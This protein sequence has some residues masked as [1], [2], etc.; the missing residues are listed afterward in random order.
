MKYTAISNPGHKVIRVFILLLF[1][2]LVI[3]QSGCGRR[4]RSVVELQKGVWFVS[5]D[6]G[7]A[8]RFDGDG[9]RVSGEYVYTSAALATPVPFEGFV[10]KRGQLVIPL[11]GDPVQVLRGV[12]HLKTSGYLFVAE[13]EQEYRFHA[14]PL[15]AMPV[16]PGRFAVPK[17]T[18]VTRVERVYGYAPGYYASKPVDDMSASAYPAIIMSVLQDVTV[19]MFRDSI[20]LDMDVYRPA[21]DSMVNRP[22]LVLIHGGAFVVGDKRDEFVISL[23]T[24]YA[25]C[26]YVVASINYRMGYP[27]IPGMYSQLERAIFRGVQDVRAALR[28]LSHHRDEFG[29]DPQKVILAGHSA[30]GFYS[31]LTTFKNEGEEWPSSSQ[32]LFGVRRELGCLDC[33]G[34]NLKGHYRILGAVNMWGGI[35]ELDLIQPEEEVPVL[36]IHGT[37]DRIVP[38]GYDFPFA[39]INPRLTA[40]FTRRLYGSAPIYDHMR[41]LGMDVRYIPIP[42]GAHEP[43]NNDSAVYRMIRTETGSFMHEMIGG[44]PLKLSGPVLVSESDEVSKYI[45]SNRGNEEVRWQVTGGIIVRRGHNWADVVWL[46]PASRYVV[47][48]A[49]SNN[50]GVVKRDRLEVRVSR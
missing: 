6:L 40:F 38:A 13:D 8:I 18:G 16:Y 46:E 28:Y 45:V 33:S 42:G 2:G 19:N 4:V 48:A 25:Q 50:I 27:F 37:D 44:K 7:I 23:A 39:R 22:L 11:G 24:H 34:N 36:L 43:Q 20:L 29:I 1:S 15:W 17:F 14:A 47:T 3:L 31:L 12:W 26:G 32:T 30:G 35:T 10:Q 5:P 49:T 9:A 21:I 41:R